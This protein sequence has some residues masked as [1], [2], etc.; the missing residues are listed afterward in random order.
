MM[1]GVPLMKQYAIASLLLLGLTVPAF[2]DAASQDARDIAPNFTYNSKDHWAVDDTVGNCA[3][4]DSKPSPSGISG[5]KVLG[6]KSGYSNLS[7][8]ENEINSDKSACKG[9]VE[10]A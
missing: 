9:I 7:A 1:N 2:A 4:V 3:V 10:R 6:D 8:A 5:L